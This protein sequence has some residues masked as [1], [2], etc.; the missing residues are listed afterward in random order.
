MIGVRCEPI[1]QMKLQTA[2]DLQTAGFDID[3]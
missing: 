1:T 3:N 2:Y